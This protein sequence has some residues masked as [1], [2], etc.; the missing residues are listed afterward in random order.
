M[1]DRRAKLPLNCLYVL[2]H[3][4]AFFI[5]AMCGTLGAIKLYYFLLHI[6]ARERLRTEDFADYIFIIDRMANI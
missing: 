4:R 5:L 2:E 3:S 1:R 6:P